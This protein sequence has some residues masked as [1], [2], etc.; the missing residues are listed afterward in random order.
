MKERNTCCC[1][2]HV[3]LNELRIALNKYHA[4]RPAGHY[5]EHEMESASC[6]ASS[7][8]F[9]GL[10]TL[11]E[12]VVCPKGEFEEW[13]NVKCLYGECGRC[14]VQKLPLCPDEEEGTD[15][16]EVEW[17]RFAYEET[18]S[19]KG[20]VLKK[21]N[22]VY[23]KTA[24]DV[25]FDYLKPKL[26][27]FVTHNFVARWEDA[28]FKKSI[29]SFP[30]D[31]V[32]SVVDF[33]ENYKFEIQ[34]EVQSMHWHSYQVSILVHIT[35]RHNPDLDPYNEDTFILTEY[36]FYITDDKHHDSEF[37]QHCFGLHWDHMKRNGFEPK[38]H[39][40]WSD[41][42]ASQFKSKKPFYFIS[43]YPNMTNGCS[44]LWNFFGSGH[45]KGPH[46]GAGAVVKCFIRR[47]QLKP[48]GV[49][50]QSA[51][52]VVGYLT[53]HLSER[54]ETSYMGHRKPMRRF[55]HHV[56]ESDVQ[57]LRD[58]SH[59]C[60]FV[61]GTQKLHSILATNKIQ[62]G[63]LMVK[64]LACFCAH[65]IDND[66]TNC[67]NLKWTG[68][69]TPNF[70]QPV[71]PEYMR[72]S[73]LRVWDGSI[74]YG[75]EGELLAATLDVGDIFAVNAAAG[76]DE[77]EDFWI[78][79]C[80][81]VLHTVKAPFTDKW[82]TSFTEGDEVVAGKYFQKWGLADDSYVLLRNSHSV[83]MHACFVRAVKFVMP[84]KDHRVQGN[85]MVYTL[86]AEARA[87]IMSV[88]ASLEADEE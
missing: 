8:E 77:G 13:H 45:G 18:L 19:K 30:K 36:H 29:R 15:G 51:R 10:T 63:M 9:N 2:Y 78:I 85:D 1:I 70:L 80:T 54:P 48:Y 22:L 41:G 3:E 58:N 88:I 56:L 44:M 14:G 83:Y 53:A 5:C 66:Y 79:I 67:V 7:M 17:R 23:K 75:A 69:W 81:K 32:V 27:A 57:P 35:F 26:Q 49:K 42:C 43:C 6:E 33:A 37:V 61:P 12:A 34:N 16:R 68:E 50:L 55:F 47:E 21:L 24:A 46:D 38:Q 28:Q 60:D 71:D 59:S 25:F 74:Q 62:I 82:G 40:V 84:P 73:M 65:C 86:P 64:E 4:T 52:D 87:G 72:E 31:T 20:K 11:W 39:W 76:N